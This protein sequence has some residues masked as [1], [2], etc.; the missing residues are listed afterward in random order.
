MMPEV[1]GYDVLREMTLAGLQPDL[2]VMVL[3][4]FP[5]PRNDEEKRLLQEGLVLDVVSKTAVHDNPQLLPHVLD[6]H[7]Q[8][9]RED[10]EGL[11]GELRS[12]A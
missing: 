5:E 1:S 4:N 2:P 8:V 11:E 7:L 3:T 10:D 6:W 9:T 12:A